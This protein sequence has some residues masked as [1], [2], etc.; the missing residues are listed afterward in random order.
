MAG[1]DGLFGDDGVLSVFSDDE[2]AVG[3]VFTHLRIGKDIRVR[4]LPRV[5][6]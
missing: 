2:T 3:S 4:H 6:L 5:K 1:R